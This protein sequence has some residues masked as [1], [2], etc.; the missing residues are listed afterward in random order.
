MAFERRSIY[1]TGHT[2]S[3]QRQIPYGA[4]QPAFGSGFEKVSDLFLR[5]YCNL[6][7]VGKIP[8]TNQQFLICAN[9]CSHLDSI[10]IM[11]ALRLPFKSCGLLAADDYFFQNGLLLNFVR[12][13]MH[14][15]PIS[16]RGRPHQVYSSIDACEQFLHRGGR[17][18]LAFPEGTRSKCGTSDFKRGSAVLAMKLAIPILPISIVGT[19]YVL[20]K[21]RIIPRRGKIMVQIGSPLLTDNDGTRDLRAASLRLSEKIKQS[22]REMSA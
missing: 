5:R 3:R 13:Q 22:I 14:L 11:V 19:N 1:I 15:I 8:S 10:A 2:S 6:S 21:E 12:R 16:R 4:F 20:P 9:H 17:A 18:I 7:V